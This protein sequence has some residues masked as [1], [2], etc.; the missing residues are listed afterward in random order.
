MA[1]D[2]RYAKILAAT[3]GSEYS[4]LAGMHAAYLAK[5]MSASVVVLNVVDVDMAFHSGIHYA[6]SV[7]ELERSG[8]QATAKIRDACTGLG[9]PAMEIIARGTPHSTILKIADEEGIDLI[10]MGSIGMSAI[11]RALVGSVSDRV[12]R[13]ARCPVLLVRKK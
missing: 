4:M 7:E 11:E 9:V 12:V 5:C 13:H 10:V 1:E 2:I 6:E 3:D 8:A